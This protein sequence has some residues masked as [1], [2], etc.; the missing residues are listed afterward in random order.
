MAYQTTVRPE[1]L[2]NP[3]VILNEDRYIHLKN[4]K[5]MPAID[6]LVDRCIECGFCEP[7]C[8]T[9]GLTVTPRQRIVGARELARLTAQNRSGEAAE[10]ERAFLIQHRH[11]AACGLCEK[12]CPVG[13]N[14]GAMSKAIRGRSQSAHGKSR[15]G[16][17]GG[18]TAPRWGGA[19][20]AERSLGL[21]LG[22]RGSR[23]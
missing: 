2:L 5:P 9:R 3:G 10:F 4:F 19:F 8:P 23:A 18:I 21:R 16:W 22:D 15:P 1:G 12:A 14:T 17:P 13:I 20:G 7:M 6:P 11:C